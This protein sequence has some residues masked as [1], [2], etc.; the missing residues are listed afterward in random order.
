MIR[1]LVR[2]LLSLVAAVFVPIV[3]YCPWGFLCT[4]EP[5]QEAWLILFP[6]IFVGALLVG[7]LS[8]YLA[9]SA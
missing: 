5:G 6:V 7:G 1:N 2:I 3:L 9:A 8:A 4:F